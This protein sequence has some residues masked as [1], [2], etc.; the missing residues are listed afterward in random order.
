MEE[1][2]KKQHSPDEKLYCVVQTSSIS[3]CGVLIMSET[4]A[5][6]FLIGLMRD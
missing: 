1:L 2:T 3:S 5:A 4:Q 6:G